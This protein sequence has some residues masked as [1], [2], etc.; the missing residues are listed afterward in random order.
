MSTGKGAEVIGIIEERRIVSKIRNPGYLQI[1]ESQ[2]QEGRNRV[3]PRGYNTRKE[4][5][6]GQH[7][8]LATSIKK[9]EYSTKIRYSSQKASRQTYLTALVLV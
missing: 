4:N 1:G 7:Y 5:W 6:K 2:R 8:I 9:F 3:E